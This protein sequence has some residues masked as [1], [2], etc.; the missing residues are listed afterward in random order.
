MLCSSQRL[1][2]FLL[3]FQALP[4]QQLKRRCRRELDALGGA[5][6]T[7]AAYVP[8]AAS[9]SAA[10]AITST[11]LASPHRV[12]QHQPAAAPLPVEQLP[13]LPED[14]ALLA[15]APP[16]AAADPPAPAPQQLRVSAKRK[17]A[18]DVERPDALQP[19]AAKSEV[20]QSSVEQQARQEPVAPR[21]RASQ[22]GSRRKA[23][24]AELAALIKEEAP[25][26]LP[27]L[28]SHGHSA[29]MSEQ[30]AAMLTSPKPLGSVSGPRS[31]RRAVRGAPADEVEMSDR[32]DAAPDATTQQTEAGQQQSSAQQQQS[33]AQ[34]PSA[35]PQTAPPPD[36]G[37]QVQKGSKELRMLTADMSTQP[38]L[39]A[40][41]SQNAVSAPRAEARVEAVPA[42][43][44]ASPRGQL[45]AVAAVNSVP[46]PRSRKRKQAPAPAVKA[47][48][49]GQ[50][51]QQQS[52][53]VR[54]RVSRGGAA[55]GAAGG[56]VQPRD[57]A[58]K[59]AL[60]PKCS[61][62]PTAEDQI[63]AHTA[64]LQP[65]RKVEHT[66]K[67]DAGDETLPAA[68]EP[69]PSTPSAD[70]TALVNSFIEVLKPQPGSQVNSVAASSLL[71]S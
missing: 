15:H 37:H 8:R 4:H 65:Q 5:E 71:V 59:A 61:H 66:A 41:R 3:T 40:R 43:Q 30:S 1:T 11:L 57:P 21:I 36:A 39:P 10:A 46:R 27:R 48:T 68:A 60:S 52:R 24:A 45:D 12:A 44:P 54:Q 69:V 23:A 20:V 25:V 53:E 13:Q 14:V 29:P 47:G 22:A 58:A 6:L 55:P 18:V 28:R 56:N 51:P 9:A 42:D 2:L 19:A 26:A 62:K 64:D 70:L 17:P 63:A 49:P 7:L 38:E 50:Q 67:Q 32:Q 16:M 31:S 35:A 33:S 34:Q